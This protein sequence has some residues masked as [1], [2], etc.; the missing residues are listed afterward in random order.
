MAKTR[1]LE[2]YRGLVFEWIDDGSIFPIHDDMRWRSGRVNGGWHVLAQPPEYNGSDRNLLEE[3]Q[4]NEGCLI[5][6]I[7]IYEQPTVLNVEKILPETHGDG[8]GEAQGQ[9]AGV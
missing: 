4:I 9:R 7:R 5:Y 6:M 1:L 2:K 8:E 3:F